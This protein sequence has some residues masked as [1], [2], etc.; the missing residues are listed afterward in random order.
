MRTTIIFLWKFNYKQS[1]FL[2]VVFLK[3]N[4]TIRKLNRRFPCSFKI[5]ILF[6]QKK[7]VKVRNCIILNL[8]KLKK[9][10]KRKAK[11]E[12][13]NKAKTKKY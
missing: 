3:Q 8:I 11:A 4:K 5:Q 12:A 1:F 10:A 6:A 9:Q 2:F 7:C 13:K